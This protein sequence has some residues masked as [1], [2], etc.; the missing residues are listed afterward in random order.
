[1]PV[2]DRV[3]CIH[4]RFEMPP[5]ATFSTPGGPVASTVA[6]SGTPGGG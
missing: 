2:V 1:M 4:L 3:E 5:E 6:A